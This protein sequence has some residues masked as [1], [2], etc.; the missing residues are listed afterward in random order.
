MMLSVINTELWLSAVV[1]TE[2][3]VGAVVSVVVVFSVVPVE[4]YSS[5]SS[6]QEI[7]VRLK[8][9]IRKMNKNFFI[10]FSIPKVKYYG[11]CIRSTLLIPRFGGNLQESG[12]VVEGVPDCEELVGVTHRR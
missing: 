7:M 2:D 3:T 1:E 11:W 10:F 8:Q 6:L 5:L 9:K 12:K 4:E